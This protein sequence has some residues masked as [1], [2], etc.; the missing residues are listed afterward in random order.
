MTKINN[1]QKKK[2]S[3]Q[4]S[5]PVK[6]PPINEF[7]TFLNKLLEA[8]VEKGGIIFNQQVGQVKYAIFVQTL[9]GLRIGAS[10]SASHNSMIWD[11]PHST[12][13]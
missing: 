1:T 12:K 10:A 8:F 7:F 9:G 6:R 4:G 13:S 11:P 5:P 3:K 2:K